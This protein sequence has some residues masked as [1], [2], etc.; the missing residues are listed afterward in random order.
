MKDM[1]GI[2]IIGVDHGYGNTKTANHCFR[3]G[4]LGYDTE[5]LF[6]REMLVYEGRYYLIGEG[7]KEFVGEKT[8]DDEFYLLTLAAIAMEMHDA[9]L[10]EAD[11]F[12]AAGLPLTWT[13]GQKEKFRAYLTRN[14][15]VSFTFRKT[16][17]HIRIV[18]AAVYPQG[19]AAIAESAAALE[20]M[21]MVA[22]IGNGTMNVLYVNDGVPL[23]AKMFTEKFGTYQCTLAVREAFLRQT[24]REISDA[25][26]EKVLITGTANIASSDLK[27]IRSVAAEYVKDIFRR[28]R[29]YGYDENTMMLY[30]AG[31][32][33]CLVKNFYKFNADRVIFVDDI[34]AAAKGYEYLA[35]IQMK[36][37]Q[38]G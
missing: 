12:I 33:G 6:T 14:G 26:I 3:T 32:G 21:N 10:T 17:Y 4:I 28:L 8:R 5:P 19:Y 38:I 16:D 9:A 20:G 35:E 31:G 11:V 37:G 7:H 24:Q 30:I 2:K 23:S 27:I 1:N 29:E 13:A 22:D 34:C 15:E 25:I 18:G 36:A